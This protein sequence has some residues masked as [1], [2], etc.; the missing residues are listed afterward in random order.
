M[1][2][3]RSTRYGVARLELLLSIASLALLFQVFPSLWFGLVWA[4]DVR[5]WSRGIWIG[6]NALAVAALFAIQ[7]RI[8]IR[9]AWTAVGAA[10]RRSGM[11]GRSTAR[12]ADRDA[13]Y[14]VRERR[15]AE[16]RER[17]RNRLPFT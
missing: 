11:T 1:S 12:E 7:F 8:E 9:D 2:G 14:E 10:V 6:L 15:D 13:E 4:L 3:I 5:N 16:W 17:A